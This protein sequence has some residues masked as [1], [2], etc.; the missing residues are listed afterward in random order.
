M[1]EE[2]NNLLSIP[3]EIFSHIW[4]YTNII[5]YDSITELLK[6]IPEL[7]I[8]LCAS[9]THVVIDN[10]EN[11]SHKLAMIE[12]N[13][14]KAK[15]TIK[16]IQFTNLN[17][18]LALVKKFKCIQNI[19]VKLNLLDH[20]HP[21]VSYHGEL[22]IL[23]IINEVKDNH[24][25]CQVSFYAKSDISYDKNQIYEMKY[26]RNMNQSTLLYN[27]RMMG[28]DPRPQL[29]QELQRELI[30]MNVDT[31]ITEFALSFWCRPLP[32]KNLHLI[33]SDDV[34]Q[35]YESA[36]SPNTYLGK[37]SGILNTS[38]V[39]K[40]TFEYQLTLPLKK[41]RIIESCEILN[42]ED[43]IFPLVTEYQVPIF[44][45]HIEKAIKMFPNV[46]TLHLYVE[47]G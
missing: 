40:I 47:S 29:R 10:A 42:T 27:N 39:E 41:D 9:L 36:Q 25:Q 12:K 1:S 21:E 11:L 23:K 15:V 13:A 22:L 14:P 32:C 4:S 28:P 2:I 8:N 5:N 20:V 19:D 31:I 18:I 33:C 7:Y 26:T 35:N 24:R 44:A 43:N 3:A 17:T 34:S 16:D 37:Y 45:K 6:V 46:K 30:S 38:N